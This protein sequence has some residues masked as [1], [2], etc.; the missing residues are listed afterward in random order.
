MIAEP[1][2]LAAETAQ[3]SIWDRPRGNGAA[4]RIRP[5]HREIQQEQSRWF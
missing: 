2:P 1:A 3:E 4:F 5:D